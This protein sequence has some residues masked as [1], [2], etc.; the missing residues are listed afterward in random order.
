MAPYFAEARLQVTQAYEA[1]TRATIHNVRDVVSEGECASIRRYMG[2]IGGALRGARRGGSLRAAI[3]EI[4]RR[5]HWVSVPSG[6]LPLCVP[7]TIRHA[8]IS[9]CSQSL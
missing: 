6:F 3:S 4:A 1:P 5:M 2:W 8:A 7:P 9:V